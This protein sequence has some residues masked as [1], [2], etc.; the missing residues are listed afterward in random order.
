MALHEIFTY[1][2]SEK[3]NKKAYHGEQLRDKPF[4]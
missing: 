1:C 4:K 3:E 2:C